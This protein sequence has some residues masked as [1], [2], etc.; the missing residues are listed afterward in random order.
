MLDYRGLEPMFPKATVLPH[1]FFVARRIDTGDDGRISKKEFCSEKMKPTIE[2]WTGP[3]ND[4]E[5]EFDKIDA[6]GGGQVL[7]KVIMKADTIL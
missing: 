3:I 7:F 1:L 5:A 6:D 4:M 2:K